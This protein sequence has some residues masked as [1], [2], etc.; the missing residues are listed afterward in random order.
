MKKINIGE[1]CWWLLL[2]ALIVVIGKLLI[3]DELKF[4]LHP[5][6][7]KFVISA[8]VILIVL[9]VYQ[10][11]RI[12]SKQVKPFKFG[13]FLFLIPMLMLI[14][15]GDASAI[16]FENRNVTIGSLPKTK[17][18]GNV[19]VGKEMPEE[20]SESTGD[21]V[22]DRLPADEIDNPDPNATDPTDPN[23]KHVPGYQPPAIQGDPFLDAIFSLN[24]E[25][26][27]QEIELTGFVFKNENFKENEFHVSRMQMNCCVADSFLI[28]MLVK[29]PM[30]KELEN[31]E[32]VRVKGTTKFESFPTHDGTGETK[33]LIV[34]AITVE[35]VEPLETPYVYF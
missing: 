4:Y 19:I 23:S 6:M 22:Y 10:Q 2:G 12:F 26:E 33:V 27:G 13:Y 7:N 35:K 8:E 14:L 20:Q 9:F 3:F 16:I 25:S 5:K 18:V 28:G 1:F 31:N 11:S 24:S 30:A 15:A 29:S 32:W 34:D 17:S 21:S